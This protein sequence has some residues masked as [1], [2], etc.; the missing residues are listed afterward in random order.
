MEE[1]ARHG[2]R[3]FPGSEPVALSKAADGISVAFK[4]GSQQGPFDQVTP[5]DCD[6]VM[7][8][9]FTGVPLRFYGLLADRPP[10][11]S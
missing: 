6:N 5:S 9:P 11:A 7:F 8:L 1:L 3:L 4:D 2:P 10:P